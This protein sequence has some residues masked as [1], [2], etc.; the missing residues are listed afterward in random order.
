M[1]RR[2]P[3]ITDP[4]RIER[5]QPRFVKAFENS[6]FKLPMELW[7]MI[8]EKLHKR[9]KIDY[10]DPFEKSFVKPKYEQ[11]E[12]YY[13]HQDKVRNLERLYDNEI[14]E[15]YRVIMLPQTVGWGIFIYSS[16]DTAGYR[17]RLLKRLILM[18]MDNV[19]ETEGYERRDLIT[20]GRL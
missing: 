7:F 12:Y 2:I 15:M 1:V 16:N 20:E 17:E 10:I 13:Y 4:P 11:F 5:L 14:S 19:I 9:F 3:W 8:E 18:K 6:R